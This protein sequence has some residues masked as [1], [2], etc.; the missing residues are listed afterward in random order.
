MFKQ[1]FPIN[2]KEELEKLGRAFARVLHPDN[3]AFERVFHLGFYGE[4]ECGKTTLN[5]AIFNALGHRVEMEDLNAAPYEA[6]SDHISIY[7]YDTLDDPDY[8]P[9]ENPHAHINIVAIEHPEDESALDF[10]F[11]FSKAAS[12]ESTITL[13]C[14][15]EETEQEGFAEFLADYGEP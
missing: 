10:S 9:R 7:H 5:R 6:Q 13:L 8:H 3:S 4:S 15:P 12:G 11:H 2:N 14:A 1:N